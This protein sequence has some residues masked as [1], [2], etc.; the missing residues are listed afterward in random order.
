MRPAKG[1]G[2]VK[3]YLDTARIEEV[4][5]AARWGILAGVT[6][7]PTLLA[8]AGAADVREVIREIAATA[9][10]P[11]SMEAVAQTADGMVAEGRQFAAWDERVVVKIPMTA[12]GLEA[13]SR[14]SADGIATNVTLVFSPAQALLAARAGARYVSPFVGRLDDTAWDGMQLVRDVVEIFRRHGIGTEVIAASIRHPVH[15]VEAARAGAHIATLPFKVLEAIIRHPLTDTGV[16]RFLADW[17]RLQQQ[18][19][20]VGR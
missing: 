15:V 13:V 9:D 18:A 16:E 20:L 2:G 11:V 12:E 6:T 19:A 5:Q 4:R 14:L 7:N 3:I 1:G 17:R 10:G 8:G